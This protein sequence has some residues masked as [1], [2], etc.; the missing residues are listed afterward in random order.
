MAVSWKLDDIWPVEKYG[1]L[2]ALVEKE[3]IKLEKWWKVL[4]PEMSLEKF[5]EFM[6][7]DQ[8]LEDLMSRMGSL[9]MLLEAED[10]KNSEARKMKSQMMDIYLKHTERSRKIGH[11]LKGMEVDGKKRLDDINANRLFKAIPDIEYTLNY[12]R[13]SAKY[14]LSQKEEL[15]AENK[16]ANQKTALNDLRGLIESEIKYKMGSSKSMTQDEIMKL[17]YS[18]KAEMRKKAYLEILGKQKENIDK[19]FVIYQAV[20]KDWGFNA[21]IRGY[22]S[23]ISMQNFDNQISDKAIETLMKVCKDERKIFW[24][25]F[26]FKAKELGVK[27]LRRFDVYAP[28]KQV[29][30]K[31]YSYEESRDLVLECYREF[32]EE[33]YTLAK[34][35][36]DE[37][38]IEAMPKENKASGA[39]CANISPKVTPYVLLNH[40]GSFRDV[41]VMAHELGHGIHDLFASK[42]YPMAMW[43]SLPL[44]ETA[45]I[46]GEAVLFEKMLA[47]E[48]DQEVKKQMLAGK[49]ADSFASILRQNYFVIFEIK[50]HEAVTKGTTAEELS[51]LWMETL[52]EEFGDSLQIDPMF[53]YEWLYVSHIF[54]RPFY[55]YAYNFGELLSLSLY[56]RYKVE[57]KDFVD[58]IKEILKSGGSEEPAKVLAK[59]GIDIESEKFWKDG[60]E[61]IR[62]WQRQLLSV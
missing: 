15:V 31:T 42:H 7:E 41:A 30:G 40:T 34:K 35:I 50:A 11:W 36:F 33:F 43:T 2:T 16:D 1:E 22:K 10:R 21:K 37:E 26:E 46:F 49:I 9:P 28:L 59:I 61:I 44:A 13:S 48:T 4:D 12:I 51:E 6:E 62:S 19:L 24:D 60:F 47:Q 55:C 29:K 18:E 14:T 57:G 58:K 52:K 25:Y 27:K 32:D 8:R 54:E 39:F 23:A 38:H 56:A 3:S 17:A 5:R 53:R 20:A 45:S